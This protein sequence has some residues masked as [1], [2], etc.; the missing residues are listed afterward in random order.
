M[1]HFNYFC[2]KL[3]GLAFV[4]LNL[5][6]ELDMLKMDI[7]IGAENIDCYFSAN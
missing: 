5:V 2:A 3:D 6:Q 4:P 7:S 1:I